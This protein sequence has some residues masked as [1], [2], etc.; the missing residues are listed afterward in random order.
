MTLLEGVLVLA[1][2]D[3]TVVAAERTEAADQRSRYSRSTVTLLLAPDEAEKLKLAMDQ[4]SVSM[5]LRNPMDDNSYA[6]RGTR[7]AEL[8][9]I[10]AQ[11]E[12][13]KREE[14]AKK[15]AQEAEEQRMALERAH[16]D[17]ERAR[18]EF[19]LAKT[20]FEQDLFQ[21]RQAAALNTVPH[22]ET[23]ILRGGEAEK[24]TFAR[25]KNSD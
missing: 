9:P 21:A 7:L 13:K 17:I 25:S 2:D 14:L 18:D 1:I 15:R 22:W 3:N 12:Q 11:A 19:E 20:K 23:V 24:K 4:G 6:T 5:I 8:A 16:Y 10:L